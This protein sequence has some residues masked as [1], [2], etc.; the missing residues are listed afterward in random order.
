MALHNHDPC[1]PSYHLP[2]ELVVQHLHLA[3]ACTLSCRMA[4]QPTEHRLVLTRSLC[5][6]ALTQVKRGEMNMGLG[7]VRLQGRSPLASIHICMLGASKG[8]TATPRGF[9]SRLLAPN[10]NRMPTFFRVDGVQRHKL[11]K[12]TA[13]IATKFRC[14]D[15]RYRPCRME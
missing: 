3:P 13:R 4:V 7:V 2:D 14:R 6:C 5:C 8:S 9:L 11:W 12:G 15:P 10:Y 1:V